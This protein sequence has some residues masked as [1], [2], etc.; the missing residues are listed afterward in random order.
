MVPPLV[1]WGHAGRESP[2]VF[3]RIPNFLH[4]GLRR[5]LILWTDGQVRQEIDLSIRAS[6]TI[7]VIEVRNSSV[8]GLIPPTNR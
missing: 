6:A 7:G 5:G 3:D 1:L 4:G 8:S 2:T